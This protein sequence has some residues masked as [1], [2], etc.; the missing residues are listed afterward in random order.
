MHFQNGELSDQYSANLKICMAKK[1]ENRNTPPLFIAL[2]VDNAYDGDI[3]ES[4]SNNLKSTFIG[5]RKRGS[6]EVCE[7]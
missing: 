3:D 7:N 6:E 2:S 1:T 5:V 4:A